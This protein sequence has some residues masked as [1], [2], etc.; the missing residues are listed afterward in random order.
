MDSSTPLQGFGIAFIMMVNRS[1][2]RTLPCVMP[3]SKR[4]VRRELIQ[5]SLEYF[6]PG[7]SCRSIPVVCPWHPS[8]KVARW[9]PLS[10]PYRRLF[11][12]NGRLQESSSSWLR[13][14]LYPASVLRCGPHSLGLFWNQ[15]V[16][17]STC[18]YSPGIIWVS[19]QS[20]APGVCR[21]WKS[22]RWDGRRTDWLKRANIP[23]RFRRV[24]WAS[25]SR[26]HHVLA[27]SFRISRGHPGSRRCLWNQNGGGLTRQ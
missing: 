25:C 5:P 7:G 3:F 20:L 14:R 10:K 27:M 16:T 26:C 4:V 8:W 19:W 18:F 1:G 21:E 22:E 6:Y 15:L 23:S 9:S 17:G 2:L 11:P 12:S 24:F 13:M